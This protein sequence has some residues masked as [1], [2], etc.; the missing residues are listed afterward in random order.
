MRRGSV[1]LKLKHYRQSNALTKTARF[2][3]LTLSVLINILINSCWQFN[4]G[5]P[6]R[7]VVGHFNCECPNRLSQ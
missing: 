5:C 6:N 1:M 2:A 3:Y 7:L 4:F